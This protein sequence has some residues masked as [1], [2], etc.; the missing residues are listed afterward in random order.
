MEHIFSRSNHVL[1][2]RFWRQTRF[3]I[4]W[5]SYLQSE[6]CINRHV[7]SDSTRDSAVLFLMDRQDVRTA[8]AKLVHH[9]HLHTVHVK[10][11]FRLKVGQIS[12]SK[13]CF[14]L[15]IDILMDNWTSKN[16][17]SIRYTQ[18]LYFLFWKSR[19]WLYLRPQNSTRS[20]PPKA[21]D[22]FRCFFCLLYSQFLKSKIKSTNIEYI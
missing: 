11:G 8:H 3:L 14:S 10:A 6:A 15:R 22:F 2:Y 5:S 7:Y 12:I 19:K 20:R 21:V 16:I 18:Y 17:C 1:K 13:T 9:R 4:Y